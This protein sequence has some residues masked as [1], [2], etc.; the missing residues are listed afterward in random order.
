MPNKR[1]FKKYVDA[2]GASIVEEMM[3]AYYNVEGA[4]KKAIGNAVGTV[5][6]AVEDAKDKANVYFDRGVKS[7]ES[8]KEYGVEKRKFFKALF[9][10]I[11]TD[12]SG[13]IDSAIKTFNAALPEKVKEAQKAAANAK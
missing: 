9:H 4:D 11:S 2:L 12:F 7:F 3:V 13:E 10:K 5:L 1:E 6:D 8:A